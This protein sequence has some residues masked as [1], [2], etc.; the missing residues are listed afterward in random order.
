MEQ[1]LNRKTTSRK[2]WLVEWCV[3]FGFAW[4][5]FSGF[6]RMTD[7][8]INWYWYTLSGIQP[9]PLYLVISGGVWGLFGLLALV[10]LWFGLAWSKRVASGAA[11]FITLT[12]W[13]DRLL[14]G[15]Q[16]MANHTFPAVLTLLGLVYVGLV[17]RPWEETL[18]K[19]ELKDDKK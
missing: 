4:L 5:A 11:V 6:V 3:Y 7:A 16:A 9:G 1:R 15:K 14:I 2:R 10:W 12:F 8:I 18:T 13:L 19:K 17:L